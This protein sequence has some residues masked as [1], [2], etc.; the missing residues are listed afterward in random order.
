VAEVARA[1]LTRLVSSGLVEEVNLPVELVDPEGVWSSLRNGGDDRGVQ[2]ENDRRLAEVFEST[3]LIATPTTPNQP[4]GH[5]GPGEVLSVALTWA[6]NLSGHPALSL[7]A[8]FAGSSSSVGLQ[9]VARPGDEAGLLAVAGG[10]GC[11]GI[12]V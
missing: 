1:A 9:L 2:A 8:G 11:G 5:D 7:P 12:R 3:D 4:H 10:K 6:F